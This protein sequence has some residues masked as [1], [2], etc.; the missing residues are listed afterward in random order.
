MYEPTSPIK[1]PAPPLK[2][3]VIKKVPVNVTTIPS[4]TSK[5]PIV[6]LKKTKQPTSHQHIS[7]STLTPIVAVKEKK[8]KQPVQ[9]TD[10]K[11]KPVTR[12]PQVRKRK[13]NTTK[14]VDDSGMLVTHETVTFND[15]QFLP[16]EEFLKKQK[17][18]RPSPDQ[19]I[20]RQKPTNLNDV[21]GQEKAIGEMRKWFDNF[22]QKISSTSRC[23]LLVGPPG[24]GKTLCAELLLREKSF[25]PIVYSFDQQFHCDS[26]SKD[27][28]CPFSEKGITEVIYKTLIRSN[29]GPDKA[30]VVLDNLCCLKKK[31]LKLLAEVLSGE[32]LAKFKKIHVS[33]AWMAPIIITVDL[34]EMASLTK[35]ARFCHVIDMPRVKET[36]LTPFFKNICEKEDISLPEN[37]IKNVVDGCGGDVRRLLNTLHFFA[38]ESFEN[39]LSKD[40]EKGV[41]D[42]STIFYDETNSF[43]VVKDFLKCIVKSD[44]QGKESAETMMFTHKTSLAF[45]L[46]A[47]HFRLSEKLHEKDWIG[48]A[49]ETADLAAENDILYHEVYDARNLFL[50]DTCTTSMNW[51]IA[52]S[53]VFPFDNKE[54]VLNT[55]DNFKFER[56]GL[57]G[58][59]NSCVRRKETMS[60]FSHIQERGLDMLEM[61]QLICEMVKLYSKKETEK[62]QYLLFWLQETRIS[63]KDLQNIWKLSQL[64]FEKEETN[65]PNPRGNR[66]LRKYIMELEENYPSVMK[67]VK[68]KK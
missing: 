66:S 17:A 67:E 24:V 5:A 68:K 39:Y 59:E 42:I 25:S 48:R 6:N 33:R 1:K 44:I 28:F 29:N 13:R 61:F 7:L 4:L 49:I 43:N 11:P 54:E 18:S 46:L 8:F 52:V 60:S 3:N 2:I 47:N 36:F 56:S 20:S 31:A 9:T 22:S 50:L 51:G 65:L 14:D 16:P 37:L 58:F 15:A 64:D 57:Y 32:R 40:G 62:D 45:L 12:P 35:I 10:Q 30:G 63:Y 19:I 38:I 41:I 53:T 27:A 26:G 34:G 23:L 21:I 55:I